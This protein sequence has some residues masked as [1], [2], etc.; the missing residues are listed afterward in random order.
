MVLR[1]DLR[2][3]TQA[4]IRDATTAVKRATT[5]AADGLKKDLRG[6]VRNAGLGGRLANTWRSRHYQNTGLDAAGFVWSQ[7]PE[8]MRAHDEGATIQARGGKFLAIPTAN[9]PKRGVGGK[10]ISPSTFPEAR[11]GSLRFVSRPGK[12]AL[13]VADNLRASYSRK[14]GEMRGFRKA[15]E[16]S[17]SGRATVVMFILV[18][19]VKLK[20]KLDV[21]RAS[22]H[23]FARLPELIVKSFPPEAR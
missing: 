10:R 15:S 16:R 12:P 7:A 11:F 4:E 8:I 1:G 17:R 5:E 20:K 6:Q 9:A 3:I 23:W 22:N 13:L 18:P 2:K 14:T 19:Q 21:N